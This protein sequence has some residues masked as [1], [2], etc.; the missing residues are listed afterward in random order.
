ML[1]RAFLIPTTIAFAF[2][3]S[4]VLFSVSISTENEIKGNL[5]SGSSNFIFLL[6]AIVGNYIYVSSS[7]AEES[8]T[9]TKKPGSRQPMFVAKCSVALAALLAIAALFKSTLVFYLDQM[10]SANRLRFSDEGYGQIQFELSGMIYLSIVI[11]FYALF[12]YHQGSVI[13]RVRWLSVAL[14][15][16]PTLPLTVYLITVYR[17]VEGESGTKAITA[18]AASVF[19]SAVLGLLGGSFAKL[20]NRLNWH[21]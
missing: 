10:E 5:V 21:R 3:L 6:A 15:I 14:S 18:I 13:P 19:G 20:G 1:V 17:V 7:Q 12:M 9:A 11:P 4:W 16:L 2:F 8:G